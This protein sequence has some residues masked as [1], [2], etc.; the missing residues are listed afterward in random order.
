MRDC[1]AAYLVLRGLEH[2]VSRLSDHVEPN[3]V[4]VSSL[5][6][7]GAPLYHGLESAQRYSLLYGPMSYLPYVWALRIFGQQVLS[8]KLVVAVSANVALFALLWHAYRTRLTRAQ[9][10]WPR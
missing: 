5:V 8:V 7:R 2:H 1:P 3:I 10:H 6:S 4:A 9:R